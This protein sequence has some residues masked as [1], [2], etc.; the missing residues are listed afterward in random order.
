[1]FFLE[2]VCSVTSRVNQHLRKL[3]F[4]NCDGSV[5]DNDFASS[6]S[7]KNAIIVEL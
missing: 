7:K 6:G 5:M 1:M 2:G 4:K 3:K